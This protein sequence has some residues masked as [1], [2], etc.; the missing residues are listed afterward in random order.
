M[1]ELEDILNWGRLV[2]LG[3]VST[4]AVYRFG[5]IIRYRY[6]LHLNALEAKRI[7]S[8]RNAKFFKFGEVAE[9]ISKILLSKECDL[10]VIRAGLLD[11]T[12]NSVDL[13][14]FYGNRC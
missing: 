4:Y 6:K 12:F 3:L 2:A 11:G 9:S 1:T 14:N 8:E 5:G 7:L 13:V 10:S